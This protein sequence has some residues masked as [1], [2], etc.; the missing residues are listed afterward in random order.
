MKE[1]G[2]IKK[3]DTAKAEGSGRR[4]KDELRIRKEQNAL[5]R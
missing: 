4:L 1:K 2:R 5:S 3:A